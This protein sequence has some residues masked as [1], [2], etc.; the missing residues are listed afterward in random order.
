MNGTIWTG[1]NRLAEKRGLVLTAG[2]DRQFCPATRRMREAIRKGYLGGPPVHMESYF[3]YDLGYG[4]YAK[5][6]LADQ[7]HWVR[8]LPGQLLHNIISHGISRIAEYLQ[9]ASP[10]VA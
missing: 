3:G 8:K 9:T 5:A 6:L 7:Q 2:H 10:E 4:A 1:Q